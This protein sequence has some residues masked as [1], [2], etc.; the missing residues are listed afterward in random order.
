LQ[1]SHSSQYHRNLVTISRIEEKTGENR[2]V[3]VRYSDFSEITDISDLSD[4]SEITDISD[5]SDI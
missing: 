3:V 1:P 5:L 2:D 4:I